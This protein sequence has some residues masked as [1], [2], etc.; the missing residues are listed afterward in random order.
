MTF[1]GL[2]DLNIIRTWRGDVEKRRF[3]QGKV[4]GIYLFSQKRLGLHIPPKNREGLPLI[5]DAKIQSNIRIEVIIF[6]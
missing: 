5:D 3:S 4:R 6:T 2:Q 1:Q